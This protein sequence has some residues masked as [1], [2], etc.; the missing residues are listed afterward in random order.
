VIPTKVD[1]ADAGPVAGEFV[2]LPENHTF[3]NGKHA[4]ATEHRHAFN[5]GFTFVF[6]VTSNDALPVFRRNV[7]GVVDSHL[8]EIPVGRRF[9]QEA[10]HNLRHAEQWGTVAARL[11]HSTPA[12]TLKV[13]AHVIPRAD[14]Q[15]TAISASILQAAMRG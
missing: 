7:A 9:L 10:A 12:T 5:P 2:R 8:H 11:G 4:S 15:A 1:T 13:Y 14:D 6:R 3:R